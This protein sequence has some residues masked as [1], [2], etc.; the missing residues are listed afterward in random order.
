MSSKDRV[1]REGDD[2]WTWA[3]EES[4]PRYMWSQIHKSD[5]VNI[6]NRI[7]ELEAQLDAVRS[8]E[9]KFADIAVNKTVKVLMYGDVQAAL[10][11]END[12]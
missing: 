3:E 7:A 1:W 6:L 10:Q 8:L 11:G 2:K 9:P 5:V 4:V 12:E